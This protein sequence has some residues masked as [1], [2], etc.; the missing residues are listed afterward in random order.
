MAHIIS[1]SKGFFAMEVNRSDLVERFSAIAGAY[2][3]EDTAETS[4]TRT[5]VRVPPT[6]HYP[7][8]SLAFPLPVL[9]TNTQVTQPLTDTP[10]SPRPPAYPPHCTPPP[11]GEDKLLSQVSEDASASFF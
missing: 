10:T 5:A 3:R 7:L 2:A 8:P 6:T 11:A 1:Q 4:S 9:C